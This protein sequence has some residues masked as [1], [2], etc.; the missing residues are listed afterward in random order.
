LILDENNYESSSVLSLETVDT[1]VDTDIEVC[2]GEIENDI[3]CHDVNPGEDIDNVG[4][5]R[6]EH[7]SESDVEG[8]LASGELSMSQISGVLENHAVA[9]S[10]CAMLYDFTFIGGSVV[11]VAEEYYESDHT[12]YLMVF[13][14]GTVPGV[15]ARTMMFVRPTSSSSNTTVNAPSGCDALDFSASLTEAE[16]LSVP[17]D[18]PWIVD[19]RGVTKD[20][21][22][23]DVVFENIDSIL[24]GFYEG[25]TVAELEAQILDLEFIYTNL[26]EL[27]LVGGRTADLSEATERDTGDDFPGFENTDGV[28]VLGLMCGNCQNP[29]PIVLTVLD[30][31]G[32]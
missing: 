23:N 30:P 19:W 5:I 27:E 16:P 6:F 15:G 14:E 22:G 20:S 9:D 7:L 29:S 25:V 31:G 13:T 24:I 10:T 18:G 26:W 28:W 11:A 4:L 32:T 1:A 2:W 21:Q 3:Q 12:T 8:L 17:M